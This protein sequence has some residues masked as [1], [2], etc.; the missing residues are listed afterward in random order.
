MYVKEYLCKG[1]HEYRTIE[2]YENAYDD[3]C[4]GCRNEDLCFCPGCDQHV[5]IEYF[6]KDSVFCQDCLKED[7]VVEED[8][9]DPWD[10]A[11]ESLK[12]IA[13]TCTT[14]H[15][16]WIHD[17]VDDQDYFFSPAC[18]FHPHAKCKNF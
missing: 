14:N 13:K 2:H 8:I 15:C 10:L 1:C 11:I 6:D 16:L 12:E 3:Y 5:E 17:D 4:F 7:K 18:R 9:E